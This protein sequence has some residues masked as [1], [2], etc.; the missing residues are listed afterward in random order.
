MA[1]RFH[2]GPA[3]P[4]RIQFSS[5]CARTFLASSILVIIFM[6][7]FPF[8]YCV[9]TCSRPRFLTQSQARCNDLDR[10]TSRIADSSPCLT[11]HTLKIWEVTL[12]FSVDSQRP[13]FAVSKHQAS[14]PS[15]RIPLF[16]NDSPRRHEAFL[17]TKA[18]SDLH[19]HRHHRKQG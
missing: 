3:Q 19:L 15:F 17:V 16:I 2:T 11:M 8:F 18:N 13:L 12:P 14:R 7:I 5:L 6:F 4:R 1:A 10:K 9:K